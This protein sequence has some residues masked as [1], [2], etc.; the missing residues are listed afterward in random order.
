[1]N[2]YI[3]IALLVLTPLGIIIGCVYWYILKAVDVDV[4]PVINK[5]VVDFEELDEKVYLR[6][7]SWGVSGN[8]SEIILSA[9]PIEPES[10]KSTKE[11]DYIFYTSELY[12]KKK[13]VDTLLIYAAASSI[14]SIPDSFVDKIKIVPVKLNTY[15]SLQEYEKKYREYGLSKISV[16]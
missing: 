9:L 2:K 10:R 1:M 11:R 15:D 3:K 5:Q 12:Y 14:G 16:N 13:G 4:S 8:H 7:M 6:A